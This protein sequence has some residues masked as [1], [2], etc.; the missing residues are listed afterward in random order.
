MIY[1]RAQCRLGKLF[2]SQSANKGWVKQALEVRDLLVE[3]GLQRFTA[4][5]SP[6]KMIPPQHPSD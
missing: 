1:D 3:V 4:P 5:P 2:R 6:T